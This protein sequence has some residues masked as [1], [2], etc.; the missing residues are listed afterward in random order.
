MKGILISV[1][2]LQRNLQ[3]VLQ[4][5]SDVCNVVKEAFPTP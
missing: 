5:Q 4:F 3:R 1:R 2:S